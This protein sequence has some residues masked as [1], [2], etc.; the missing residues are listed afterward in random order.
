[1]ILRTL[2]HHRDGVQ[3]DLRETICTLAIS[4]D[5]Q[6]LVTA[7]CANRIYV[8]NMDSLKLHAALP[9]FSS[10]H[11]ALAFHES[12]DNI[13]VACADNTV[14]AYHVDTKQVREITRDTNS[15]LTHLLRRR[16]EKIIGIL[17]NPSRPHTIILWGLGY[18]S[19]L[20]IR[21]VMIF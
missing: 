13:I 9:T 11:T 17:S 12:S 4:A 8:V 21:Q 15:R 2:T 19:E 14:Y 10:R 20:D 16:K 1:V 7:D 3:Y 5:A 6:W 18:L